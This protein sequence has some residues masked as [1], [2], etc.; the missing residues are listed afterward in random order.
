VSPG[1]AP[2]PNALRRDRKDDPSWTSLPASHKTPP[3]VWPLPDHLEREAELWS[4]YWA[5]PQSLLWKLNNQEIEVALFVRRL[6]EVEIANAPAT[7][8]TLLLKQME[9]LL[10]TIPA[11]YKAHVKIVPE[12]MKSRRNAKKTASAKPSTS[13]VRDRLKVVSSGG[14]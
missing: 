8:H 1:P 4:I 9:L 7:L 3:P 14:A 12:E 11:M 5:K 6:S 13:S 10:L 2:D